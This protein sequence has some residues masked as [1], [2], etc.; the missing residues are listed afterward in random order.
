MH[1]SCFKYY[2]QHPH[3]E[4]NLLKSAEWAKYYLVTLLINPPATIRRIKSYFLTFYTYYSITITLTILIIPSLSI[5]CTI[6]RHRYCT[7]IVYS[8]YHHSP[9]LLYCYCLFFVPSLS[10]LI[11]PLLSILCNITLHPYYTVIVYSL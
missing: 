8:L 4:L 10:I 11:I 2:C 7:V 6:T 9:S 3:A 1:Y 5:L